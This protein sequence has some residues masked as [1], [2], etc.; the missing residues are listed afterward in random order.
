[1]NQS[2]IALI[3]AAGKGTRM[4]SAR[5]KVLHEVFF[6]PMLHHVLD[7]VQAA[8]IDRRAIIVGHQRDA[9]LHT[10]DDASVLPVVQE[11]QLGTGH[12]VLCAE[13]VCRQS[14][15]VL[16]LCG[17]TP[18][19]QAATLKAMIAE[20]QR[21]RPALTL[22]TTHLDQPF[23][24]GRIIRNHQTAVQA[25]VEEKDANDQQRAIREINAG[26]YLTEP[27]FLFQALGRVDTDNSQGEVYL[28]D[29]VAIAN[30]RGLRAE[31]FVHADAIDVLG[32]N[33]RIELAQAHAVLQARRNVALMLDG[34]TMYAPE[35]ILIAPDCVVGRDTVIE[36]GV[37]ITGATTVGRDCRLA[38][39]CVLRDCTIG[40]AAHIGEQAVLERCRI[41]AGAVIPPLAY[42][43]GD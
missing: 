38:A 13:E 19:I 14:D 42:L 23:G 32:V 11:E 15:L 6:H 31:A 7:A 35:T 17:D 8:G 12:A 16:I 3:L 21:R 9:V 4:K 29:I 10:L 25:I 28:T 33:S 1:M 24:Y 43:T 27:D 34:V 18:L 26:I 36:A 30:R 5:A 2:L 39:G 37:Q 20:H 41:S 40:D 22:M